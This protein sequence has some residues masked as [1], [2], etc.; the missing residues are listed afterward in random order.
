MRW[1]YWLG[2]VTSPLQL[3]FF[4]L[5]NHI[6]HVPRSRVFVWNEYDEVLLVRNWGGRNQWA[7]PG[8]GVQRKEEPIVAAKRELYEEIGIDLPLTD[9]SYVGTV[10]YQYE[11]II[12]SVHIT[13][14]I[15]P[16]APHNPW[17]ITD[18]QWFSLEKLPS[19]LSPVVS[20]ALKKLSKSN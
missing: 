8:G 4:Y 3:A 6:F 12:Y 9:F 13:T 1:Y 16:D 19:D 14:V 7:L 11:A 20:L 17:E 15:L 10:Q 5:F 18:M 2:R